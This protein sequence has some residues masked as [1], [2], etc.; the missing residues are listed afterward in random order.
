VPGEKEKAKKD[1]FQKELTNFSQAMKSFHK[2]DYS[3]A[4]ELLTQLNE[5]EDVERELADRIKTY[6]KICQDKLAKK[7]APLK[8]FKDYYDL[9]VYKANEGD[10]Q[11]AISLLKKAQ[12][13]DPKEGKAPYLLATV[14]CKMEKIDDCLESLKKAIQADNLLA[15]LAQ[16][17]DD[18]E[19]LK[20]D[21]EFK[22]IT[23]M[24]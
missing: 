8:T 7:S 24:S 20:E 21:Q 6:L 16:N 2:G 10:Y 4:S 22:L 1:K 9:G 5:K 15:V 17:E 19:S 13:L 11:E 3:K 12:E 14:F 18:F 23:Q